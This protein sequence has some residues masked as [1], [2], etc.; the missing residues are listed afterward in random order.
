V[1][2]A[3]ET[4]DLEGVEIAAAGVTAFGNEGFSDGAQT[5]VEEQYDV[6][7]LERIAADSNAAADLRAPL[8]IGHSKR[9]Q[10]LRNSGLVVD[11]EPAAGWL[12]NFRVKGDKLLCDL[13]RV[14]KTLAQLA[15][16]AFRQR[17]VEVGSWHDQQNDKD[18]PEVVRGLALLG[19]TPPAFQTLSDLVAAFSADGPST[20][21]LIAADVPLDDPEVERTTTFAAAA[22]IWDPERGAQDVMEALRRKLNP[23]NADGGEPYPSR[24]WVRDVQIEGGSGRALVDDYQTGD[25]NVCWVVPFNFDDNGDPVPADSTTWTLAQQAWIAASS[26]AADASVSAAPQAMREDA[27][28]VARTF[29]GDP[30]IRRDTRSVADGNLQSENETEQTPVELTPAETS[31]LKKLLVLLGL[32][33]ADGEGDEGEKDKAPEIKPDAVAAF[34]KFAGVEG[35]TD[36]AKVLAAIEERGKAKA[37][38]VIPDGMVV[39]SA[40]E[41][42][43]L[44]DMAQAGVEAKQELAAERKQTFLRTFARRGHIAP[45]DFDDYGDMYDKLG[46]EATKAYLEKLPV[47][48]TVV[49][50][51][52]AGERDEMMEI[53]GRESA[54]ISEDAIAAYCASTGIPYL[55]PAGASNGNGSDA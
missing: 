34:A 30:R 29:S 40:D 39:F 51:F 52:G 36:L 3:L 45:A 12:K 41:R 17:S 16:S 53:L 14:P 27:V 8:K 28:V 22:I 38:P 19:T 32:A 13:E 55:A 4:V 2:D 5:P 37:E 33:K 25:S 50:T 6:A 24:Y 20:V 54:E 48:E 9:Q 11:E 26:D 43:R 21:E 44:E 47:D 35:E 18:Y 1:A 46:P 10:L 7:R 49:R 31:G 23:A 42:K 15:G